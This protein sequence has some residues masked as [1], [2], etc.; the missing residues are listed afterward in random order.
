MSSKNIQK[1][2]TNVYIDGF[3]FYYGCIKNTSYKW[4]NLRAMCEGILPDNNIQAIKYFTAN[5][6]GTSR[7]PNKPIRQQVYFRALN[8]L[9][10]FHIILGHF[11]TTSK[12]MPLSKTNPPKFV[13]VDKVE[14]KGSDVNLATHLLVDAFRNSFDVAV[15]VT[16]DSDLKEPMRVVRNEFSKIVLLL[17]PHQMRFANELEKHADWKHRIQAKHLK[18]CQFPDK[19]VDSRG[20]FF[21]PPKW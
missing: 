10:N 14:E 18:T 20:E 11:L 9:A 7:D 16:N 21:K 15:I 17:N 6:S 1:R 8:T 5:V 19:L 3:N 13:L 4:V 12:N 2:R